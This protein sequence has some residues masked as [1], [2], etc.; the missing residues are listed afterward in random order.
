MAKVGN[1]RGKSVKLNQSNSEAWQPPEEVIILSSRW[2]TI[3]SGGLSDAKKGEMDPGN[4]KIRIHEDMPADAGAVWFHELGHAVADSCGFSDAVE[5]AAKMAGMDDDQAT[6]MVDGLD[7]VVQQLF[8]QVL[9]D[10]LRRN[11][12]DFS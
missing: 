9:Y 5:F 10:T 2:E 11:K 8:M 7:E 4:R 12:I 3:R 6:R 1:G